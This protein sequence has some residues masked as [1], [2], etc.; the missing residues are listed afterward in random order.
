MVSEPLR[1]L[2]YKCLETRN[3]LRC[4][5]I[6]KLFLSSNHHHLSCPC[7]LAACVRISSFS[8]LHSRNTL[9]FK[10]PTF[11]SPNKALYIVSGDGALSSVGKEEEVIC[12]SLTCWRTLARKVTYRKIM[13]SSVVLTLRR[14]RSLSGA[15][16]KKYIVTKVTTH[17]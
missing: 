13:P 5:A 14:S 1:P 7:T 16:K 8:C 4:I 6:F 10:L 2:L 3:N 17:S 12:F 11:P 9:F 15:W